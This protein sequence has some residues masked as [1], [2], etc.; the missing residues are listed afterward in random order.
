VIH[1]F[2]GVPRLDG[3]GRRIAIIMIVS[4]VAIQAQAL[5]LM[6]F[7]TR[8]VLHLTSEQA[9]VDAAD[10]LT[11]LESTAPGPERQHAIAAIERRHRLQARWHAAPPEG[12][13][14]LRRD[15]ALSRLRATL[16]LR[17]GARS[18][19]V[20]AGFVD[21]DA[22][23]PLDK[24][25]LAFDRPLPDAST[26]RDAADELAAGAPPALLPPNVS[27]VIQAPDGRWLSLQ[28]VAFDE[29]GWLASRPLI[30]MFVGSLIIAF[31]SVL[32][33][34]TIASP[35][36]R[37]VAAAERIGVSRTFVPVAEPG[38]YEFAAVASAFEDMQRRLLRHIDERTWLLASISQDLRSSL[39][40]LRLSAEADDA[41][42]HDSLLREID[43]MHGM[44]DATIA[45]G[46]GETDRG[47]RMPT[48]LG[49][50]LISMVD[51]A[52]DAGHQATYAGPDHL[53][54]VC[55]PL[56]FKRAFRNLLD[57]AIKYGGNARVGLEQEAD[58]ILL[59]IEDDGPGIPP[60][61]MAEALLPFRRLQPA[62]GAKAGA[63]LGLSIAR[64]AILA[65]GGTLQLH[66]ARS[67]G[68]RVEVMLLRQPDSVWS[69]Q[70]ERDA[71]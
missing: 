19:Q 14:A 53:E 25:Q 27:V 8:P 58:R 49:A 56:M 23:F 51:D 69:P 13:G 62:V 31:I 3:I 70:P 64:D 41:A 29:P 33:A 20:F 5:V 65:H 26:G 22:P 67:G 68:L 24:L 12:I 48:D 21:L 2:A 57:N 63:G 45:F 52:C 28:P 17:L 9:L 59:W 61:Q 37:L 4:L 15:V 71:L 30:P 47:P 43:D 18:R 60:S 7:F 55:S 6:W 40:R 34:R 32:T 1:A 11:R 35:L 46:K 50:L 44:L 16:R 10:A 38:L 42:D 66:D 36:R 54:I 39:T